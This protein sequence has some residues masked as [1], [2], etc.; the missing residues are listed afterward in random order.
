MHTEVYAGG[1]RDCL[2][3]KHSLQKIYSETSMP[4]EAMILGLY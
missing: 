2:N 4:K 3:L 1:R